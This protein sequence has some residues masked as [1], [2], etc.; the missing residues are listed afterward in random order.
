MQY[1]VL[2]PYIFKG[3]SYV[4]P[5]SDVS[6][7]VLII[8]VIT[9]FT[10][11]CFRSV[12]NVY[13]ENRTVNSISAIIIIYPMLWNFMLLNSIFFFVDSAVVLFMT[14]GF[15]FI[16]SKKNY[17]LLL[18]VFFA[19]LNHYS[20]AFIIMAFV[21]FNYKTL[22]KKQTLIFSAA[23][24]AVFLICLL[25][26]KL[27]YPYFPPE[28]EDGFVMAMPLLAI[29][30]ITDMPMSIL[31]KY[32]IL[33]FGGLHLLALLVMVT[34]LWKKIKPEFLVIFLFFVPYCL[35]A[36]LRLGIRLEEMRNWIP[37]IP[38]I[39][40]LALILFTGFKNPLFTL[41]KTVLKEK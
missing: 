33:N 7:F 12:L 23:L 11:L 37:L 16:V 20:S 24:S 6:L 3:L 15:Y 14:A 2:I 1:R 21:L 27:K 19:T 26:F 22:F 25:G 10:L 18:T 39:T 17:W 38:F 29:E 40:I 31:L 9:Y 36:I 8:V 35:I 28:R 4:L 13:F 32:V 5:L 34:G 41:S 30:A